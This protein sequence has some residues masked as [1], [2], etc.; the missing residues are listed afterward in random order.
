MSVKQ[1]LS[2]EARGI[3]KDLMHKLAED[4]S[5]AMYRT[6]A[7]APQPHLPIAMSGAAPL[8]AMMG[9]LIDTDPKKE[10]DPDCLLLAG[11]L[12][13]RAGGARN[14]DPIG[15]AYKDFEAL[16]AAGRTRDTLLA[17]DAT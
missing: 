1:R 10:P 12:L 14:H 16:K 2:A 7:I 3:T 5:A 13:A 9:A 8:L 17:K 15:E 11:L 4:V 6:L